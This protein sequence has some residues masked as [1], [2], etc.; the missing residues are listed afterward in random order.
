MEVRNNDVFSGTITGQ[1]IESAKSGSLMLRITA[2]LSARLID[3]RKGPGGPTEAVPA[4]E[5][6]NESYLLFIG[7]SDKE[8]DKM[9]K[10]LTLLGWTGTDLAC[11]DPNNPGHD[12]AKDC[13]IGRPVFFRRW[14][15]D[16]GKPSQWQLQE[17]KVPTPPSE[18]QSALK[19]LSRQ[20]SGSIREKMASVAT[21]VTAGQQT[22]PF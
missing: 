21:P 9:A 18:T 4:G 5:L 7:D 17:V 16:D 10:A 19:A 3:D 14:I 22:T 2:S 20:I 8:Q 12:K 13:F 1:A 11:L 15:R 6:T